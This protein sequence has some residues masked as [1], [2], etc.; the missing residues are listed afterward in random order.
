MSIT[1]KTVA[2]K[3]GAYLHHRSSLSD[4]VDWAENTLM[5]ANFSTENHKTIRDVVARLGVADVRAFGLT[6]DDCENFLDSLGYVAR[7]EIV[8]ERAH[9]PA[10]TIREK[11][12]RKYGK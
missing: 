6:W 8:P 12:A 4:L 5:D 1:R 9:P 2:D 11:P 10:A 7:I 3:I